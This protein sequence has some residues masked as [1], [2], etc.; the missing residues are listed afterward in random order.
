MDDP[1]PTLFTIGHSNHEQEALIELLRR[2]AIEVLADVRSQPWS[3]H[4][5]QFNVEPLKAALQV[6]GIKYLFLG[7]QLG[8]RP[9]GDEQ[10][11]V[12][13]YRLAESPRFRAGIERLQGGIRAT[14]VALMCSEE[15]PSV[16][17]RFLLVTRVLAPSGIDIRHIR[18][19]GRLQSDAELRAAASDDR[20]QGLLFQEMECDAWRSLRSVLPKAPP[21]GSSAD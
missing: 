8:G 13:Y 6:A 7:D 1:T 18:G 5:P 9:E 20:R 11:Y 4:S 3:R 2:H 21:S 15:D 12:L 19:D 17:H 14:R 10:G 16:C